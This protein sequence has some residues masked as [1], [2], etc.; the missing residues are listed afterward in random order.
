MI[1]IIL[2][3]HKLINYSFLLDTWAWLETRSFGKTRKF[4]CDQNSGEFWSSFLTWIRI[5]NGQEPDL[6][7]EH[8]VKWPSRFRWTTL[9]KRFNIVGMKILKKTIEKAFLMSNNFASFCTNCNKTDDDRFLS[10]NLQNRPA[11]L[12]RHKSDWADSVF[13][14]RWE[15]NH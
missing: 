2:I 10:N 15:L 14:L 13:L 4:D 7:R 3:C 11:R 12:G 8:P 9:T 1:Q 5:W 6:L